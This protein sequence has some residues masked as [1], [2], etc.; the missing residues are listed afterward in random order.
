VE[1][2]QALDR[3]LRLPPEAKIRD[4][5]EILALI[6]PKDRA[7]FT[8]HA[9]RCAPEGA[10]GLTIIDAMADEQKGYRDRPG[11]RLRCAR[12]LPAQPDILY[13]PAI[14][15]AVDHNRHVLHLKSPVGAAA[16]VVDH[17]AHR[18]LV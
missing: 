7:E 10:D 2:N 17:R 5:N 16:K 18:I 11:V 3:L 8:Q 14:K 4:T 12:L 13:A 9:K 6:H 1:C 15:D